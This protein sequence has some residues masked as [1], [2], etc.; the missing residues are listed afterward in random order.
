MPQPYSTYDIYVRY[1]TIIIYKIFL[2][3]PGP[4][5]LFK[6]GFGFRPL[7]WIWVLDTGLD[8]NPTCLPPYQREANYPCA[9]ELYKE[10]QLYSDP[11]FGIMLSTMGY[12]LES[13]NSTLVLFWHL[14]AHEWTAKKSCVR[15][16][17][18]TCSIKRHNKGHLTWAGKTLAG[19]IH[20]VWVF[21]WSGQVIFS[22]WLKACWFCVFSGWESYSFLLV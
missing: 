15:E 14:L 22:D 6:F 9:F 2:F 16:S 19:W 7:N 5:P 13:L 12:G 1:I 3:G 11:D 18:L 8:P 21:S 4:K 10:D 17:F 20:P